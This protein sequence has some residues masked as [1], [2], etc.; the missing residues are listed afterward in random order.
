MAIHPGV[1]RVMC[2]LIA[3][4][5][6]SLAIEAAKQKQ[7][8]AIVTYATNDVYAMSAVVLGRTLVA[9]GHGAEDKTE[10]IVLVTAPVSSG[11]RT[12]LADVGWDV[13]EV[14]PIDPQ[15]ADAKGS[16]P[17]ATEDRDLNVEFGKLHAW[18][19]RSKK[20]NKPFR[21]V[22]MIDADAYAKRPLDELFHSRFYRGTVTSRYER[23]SAKGIL[24][25][26]LLAF[27]ADPSF[28]DSVLEF[29]RT[30]VNTGMALQGVLNDQLREEWVNKPDNER[31]PMWTH[32]GASACM[33]SGNTAASVHA[34]VAQALIL[35]FQGV[36]KPWRWPEVTFPVC[37][38]LTSYAQVWAA[39]LLFPLAT[40]H[41]TIRSML[42]NVDS[43]PHTDRKSV[44]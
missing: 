31:I 30:H 6:W 35:D 13:L 19:L 40:K 32:Y 20:D 4:L 9:V 24:F 7:T 27:R 21:R 11:A 39:V 41:L 14:A 25:G 29:A 38:V 34:D 23:R 26:G 44:V 5:T 18:K 8:R 15:S 42:E 10:L 17:Q 28:P 36:A 33:L 2:V 3:L 22:L 43:L 16:I 12:L 37:A 1:L